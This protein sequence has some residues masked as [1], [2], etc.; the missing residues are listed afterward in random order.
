MIRQLVLA[1]NKIII[2]CGSFC[3]QSEQDIASWET[4][5]QFAYR[6]TISHEFGHANVS[7]ICIKLRF[8]SARVSP[9]WQPLHHT[10]HMYVHTYIHIHI[11]TR[12]HMHVRFDP[13]TWSHYQSVDTLS[14]CQELGTEHRKL[15]HLCTYRTYICM[16]VCSRYILSGRYGV[17]SRYS[18]LTQPTLCG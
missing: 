5:N 10:L 1:T 13:L 2:N 7:R 18:R 12:I 4:R 17:S 14:T 6:V 3:G 8:I 16:Y 9:V 15:C 11:V